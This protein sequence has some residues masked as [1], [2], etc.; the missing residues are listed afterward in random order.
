MM[1]AG[2]CVVAFDPGE[3]TGW[4]VVRGQKLLGAG[5][6][7]AAHASVSGKLVNRWYEAELIAAHDLWDA[8][9]GVAGEDE[10]VAVGCEDFVLRGRVSSREALSPVRL[11]VRLHTLQ[12]VWPWHWVSPSDAKQA[13]T[14]ERLRRWGMWVKGSEHARDAVRVAVC[15]DRRRLK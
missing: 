9:F 14:N 8:V 12:P 2:S 4:A 15:A 13:V 11:G 1:V 7:R 6:V 10:I 5:E 3:V